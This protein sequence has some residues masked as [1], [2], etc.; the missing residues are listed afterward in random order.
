VVA[1][2]RRDLRTGRQRV[3]P[4]QAVL[5]DRPAIAAEELDDAGLARRHHVQ[6]AHGDEGREADQDA[7]HDQRGLAAGGV[8]RGGADD[9]SG[10]REQSDQP[11]QQREP[12][13]DAV[14]D[15]LPD[16]RCGHLGY[17]GGVWSVVRGHG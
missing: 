3:H 2:P 9:H 5:A 11:E 13:A 4:A 6:A 12:A 1:Y 8:H 17:V 15:G 10:A 14:R 16:A 7:G